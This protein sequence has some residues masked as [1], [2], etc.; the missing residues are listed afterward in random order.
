M[1]QRSDA[2]GG[3]AP[4]RAS[5]CRA[6]LD[7]DRDVLTAP[8]LAVATGMD[9]SN[10]KKLADELVD[11]GLLERRDPPAQRGRRGRPPT[12]AFGLAPSAAAKLEASLPRPAPLGTLSPGHQLVFVELGGDAD[13]SVVELL[14]RSDVVA[15]AAWSGLCDG[16]RQELVIA[17]EGAGAV[18]ASLDLMALFA[19]AKLKATRVAVAKVESATELLEWARRSR[20]PGRGSRL[21]SL[22]G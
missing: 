18:D 21:R 7:S 10:A 16:R 5:L 13:D 11:A 14:T 22:D 2:A 4:A 3:E 19:A 12:A 15:G 8:E 6:L 9:R 1:T 17:F 20:R